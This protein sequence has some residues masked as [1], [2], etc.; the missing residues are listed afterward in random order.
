MAFR[1]GWLNQAEGIRQTDR[2]VD[3]PHEGFFQHTTG[4]DISQDLNQK[5]NSHVF[6]FPNRISAKIITA[7]FWQPVIGLFS[8]KEAH[9]IPR[10]WPIGCELL[11]PTST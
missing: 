8:V 11:V 4:E 6:S 1:V 7:V 5:F 2:L 3:N 10:A 9:W